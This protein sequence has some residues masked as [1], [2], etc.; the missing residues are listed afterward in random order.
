MLKNCLLFLCVSVLFAQNTFAQDISQWH[1]PE[2]AKARLGKGSIED[3]AYSPDGTRLAVASSIG[4][5]L[6]ETDSY[7]EVALF[8]EQTAWLDFI[9]FSPDGKTIA[10]VDGTEEMIVRLWDA[11][12]GKHKHTLKHKGSVTSVAFSPDSKTIATGSA[13]TGIIEDYHTHTPYATTLAVWDAKTGRRTHTFIGHTDLV[14]S[15]AFSPDGK[16]IASRSRD[17][18]VRLWDAKTGAHKHTLKHPNKIHSVMFSPDSN[19]IATVGSDKTVRLW[20]AETG[21]H[22]YMLDE[23]TGYYTRAAFSPD[24]KTIATG[25]PNG[26]I[27]LWDAKTGKH[28]RSLDQQTNALWGVAFS[29]DGKTMVCWGGGLTDIVPLWDVKTGE[30]KYSF[31]HTH[32]IHSVMFSP[33]SNTLATGSFD[34][35]VRLWDA[36]TGKHLQTLTG[37]TDRIHNVAFSPDGKTIA[38]GSG[39]GTVL[40]WEVPVIDDR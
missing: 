9:K 21:R 17:K 37:H 3:F 11:K 20:N 28:K 23:H 4:I 29:P 25:S 10:G 27:H 40:L 24:G 32:G 36:K 18:T 39:D 19:T 7:R 31:K 35:K 26:S 34:G 38:T 13:D 8:T 6:Y 14:N 5:W 2:G 30:H 22:L 1:L 15:V 33:D 12:T 16:T